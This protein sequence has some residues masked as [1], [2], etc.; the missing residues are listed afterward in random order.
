[1]FKVK[2]IRIEEEVFEEVNK[3]RN[4]FGYRWTELFKYLKFKLKDGNFKNELT[5][6]KHGTKRDNK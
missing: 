2:S 6:L 4:K 5:E 3:L 1:M